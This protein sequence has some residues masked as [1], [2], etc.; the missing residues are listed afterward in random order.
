[1]SSM[2]TPRFPRSI[3]LVAAG[4]LLLPALGCGPIAFSD[5]SA[6]AIVG[7]PPGQP[8]P[9]PVAEPAPEPEPPKRVE[10]RDNKVVI[11]EKVQFEKASDRIL[12]VSHD[13]LNEVAQ[14]IKDNP[15]IKKIEVQGH[16]SAE[17]SDSYN[18]NL[19]DKRA[20]SVRKYL[21]TKGGVGDKVLTAKGYG[22]KAPIADNESEEGR[23]KNRR[24][25]FVIT[26]QDVTK[27]KVEVGEGGEETVVS[28]KTVT[29]T[30]TVD[31]ATG[32]VVKKGKGKKA[33]KGKGKKAAEEEA[34]PE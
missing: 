17:G 7:T 31:E 1:M 34:A 28:E 19:S 24:V 4:L 29:K 5:D 33:K 18:L 10:V 26:E 14:V 8:E 21:V 9:E 32:D 25:E 22:E 30:A 2:R 13:L 11:N 3:G 16:A 20:K 15:Q 6:L 12:E 27:T 23:E